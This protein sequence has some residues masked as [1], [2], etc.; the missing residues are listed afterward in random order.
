MIDL[1]WWIQDELDDPDAIPP[2][3]YRRWYPKHPFIEDQREDYVQHLDA[4]IASH[5]TAIIERILDECDPYLAAETV[6]SHDAVPDQVAELCPARDPVAL[7]V[8]RYR[9]RRAIRDSDAFDPDYTEFDHCIGGFQY[10]DNQP[11]VPVYSE[12]EMEPDVLLLTE[13]KTKP[14]FTERSESDASVDIEI[15]A[16]DRKLIR[17]V[18]G[19]QEYEALSDEEIRDLLQCVWMQIEHRLIVDVSEDFGIRLTVEES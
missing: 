7:I 14:K 8:G 10:A 9:P 19:D 12:P 4:D 15:T 18:T 5:V 17:E 11:T 3:G 13:P 6:S 2:S 1:D 16:A